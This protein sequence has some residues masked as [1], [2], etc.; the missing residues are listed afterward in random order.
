MSDNLREQAYQDFNQKSTDE[1]VRVWQTNDRVR[2]QDET[3]EVIHQIL[4]ERGIEI[5]P[6][7][8]VPDEGKGNSEFTDNK[9]SS[10]SI[11]QILF[12]FDG[13][14]GLGTFWIGTIS[15][16]ALLFFVTFIDVL[17]FDDSSSSGVL[18]LLARLALI[19]PGLALSVKRWHDRNKSGW[20][21]FVGLIPI[22]GP[23]WVFIENGLLPGT[24]G[25]NSYGSKSF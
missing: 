16:V 12:S 21:V 9:N 23:I 5:P 18:T 17:V 6:Q 7:G 14:I 4:Q 20:N 1:L 15:L 11:G 22:I 10:M 19:W 24:K 25:P 2:W 8:W 13:R 3:F